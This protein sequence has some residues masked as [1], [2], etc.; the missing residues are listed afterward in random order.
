M[1]EPIRWLNPIPHNISSDIILNT[2]LVVYPVHKQTLHICFLP[3]WFIVG[4]EVCTFA[5]PGPM[6][7]MSTV[8]DVH[9]RA[10]KQQKKRESRQDMTRVRPQQPATNGSKCETKHK[11]SG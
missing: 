2:P 8:H 4:W 1:I 5:M 3:A 9:E 11:P 7:R 10:G 6:P